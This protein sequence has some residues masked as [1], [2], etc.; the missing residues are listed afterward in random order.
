MGFESWGDG[1]L[2][3][4]WV[5]RFSLPHHPLAGRKVLQAQHRPLLTPPAATTTPRALR[6]GY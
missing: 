1:V 3:G 2:G 5:S 6:A 4:A